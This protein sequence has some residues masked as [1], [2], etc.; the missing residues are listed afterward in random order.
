MPPLPPRGYGYGSGAPTTF[1]SAPVGYNVQP[2]S[3]PGYGAYQD[4]ASSAQAFGATQYGGFGSRAVYRRRL[5][6]VPEPDGPMDSGI[7][8]PEH[9][10]QAPGMH[11]H[12]VGFPHSHGAGSP[13]PPVNDI[14]VGPPLGSEHFAQHG[15]PFGD[16][17]TMR[18]FEQSSPFGM[19]GTPEHP[20]QMLPPQPFD[21]HL[22]LPP[23]DAAAVPPAPAR[24]Y[25]E[26]PPMSDRAMPP[27][28]AGAELPS[29]FQEAPGPLGQEPSGA[30]PAVELTRN[31][32]E[33]GGQAAP[34]LGQAPL[35]HMQ[36]SL[37]PGQGLP[38]PLAAQDVANPFEFGTPGSPPTDPQ[39]PNEHAAM[40]TGSGMSHE[41]PG[42]L[43]PQD[44]GMGPLGTATSPG[45][46]SFGN[47][48]M[49]SPGST[50][51]PYPPS[52]HLP[53]GAERDLSSQPGQTAPEQPIPV[54]AIPEMQPSS[55]QHAPEQPMPAQT[56]PEMQPPSSQPAPEQPMLAQTDLEQQPS[57]G[58]PTVDSQ[59]SAPAN[60]E[61]PLAGSQPL[62]IPAPP[63][64]GQEMSVVPGSGVPQEAQPGQEA[65]NQAHQAVPDS[66]SQPLRAALDS[67]MNQSPQLGRDLT[68][69]VPRAAPEGM[70]Q[71]QQAASEL[72][73]NPPQAASEA[74]SQS[75][76]ATPESMSLSLQA[77]P[78]AMQQQP[79]APGSMT[80]QRLDANGSPSTI[81]GFQANA[82]GPA[83]GPS[84]PS[85]QQPL[86]GA[87]AHRE[88]QA[89]S[90]S[91]QQL[92]EASV[93]SRT[94]S[95]TQ[96]PSSAAESAQA[97]IPNSARMGGV[98]EATQPPNNESSTSS[99]GDAGMAHTTQVQKSVQSQVPPSQL[100]L[101]MADSNVESNA[102]EN[103]RV[104]SSVNS[105][106]A[107]SL[108]VS[109]QPTN[110]EQSQGFGSAGMRQAA[111]TPP[112]SGD[113]MDQ[114]LA[115]NAAHASTTPQGVSQGSFGMSVRPPQG[116]SQESS[117]G[118]QQG[119]PW[120]PQG[121][122]STAS[123]LST[124]TDSPAQ[125]GQ[126]S[127][128]APPGVDKIVTRTVTRTLT[129][130]NDG[131]VGEMISQPM[132]SLKMPMPNT[133]AQMASGTMISEGPSSAMS[134]GLVSRQFAQTGRGLNGGAKFSGQQMKPPL[135]T[136][137]GTLRAPLEVRGVQTEVGLSTDTDSK[138]TEKSTDISVQHGSGGS[139]SNLDVGI[140]SGSDTNVSTSG[141]Q[142]PPPGIHG[143]G[144]LDGLCLHNSTH[145]SCGMVEA[146]TPEE[147][148]FVVNENSNPMICVRRPCSGKMVCACA[149]GANMLCKHTTV[150]TILVATVKHGDMGGDD[151]ILCKRDTLE[152]GVHVL[153]PMM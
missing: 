137:D 59:L 50:A 80:A 67:P 143:N 26:F 18:S 19:G 56:A 141:E 150:K 92:G 49:A 107:S 37:S 126:A 35:P 112:S 38:D 60:P 93:L 74:M 76:N 68:S 131:V 15:P 147:C 36:G 24:P 113:T 123:V 81:S 2:P 89:Q 133:G 31:G 42:S 61:L 43:P 45:Y 105:M 142:M 139:G 116:N 90:E 79:E 153:M 27:P 65:L 47:I 14:S 23:N 44:M 25:Q 1:P 152:D 39:L 3:Y 77:A 106:T 146:T 46:T 55:G 122:R 53:P 10:A 97:F 69:G 130:P 40:T 73:A 88:Y 84:A 32:N 22:G 57:S 86:S 104:P 98:S 63:A 111:V 134:N 85:A 78:E 82:P 66:I 7:A 12:P 16:A 13:Y 119:M 96:H 99:G 20:G 28:P 72:M 11:G 109:E 121:A 138:I 83:N 102:P 101:S 145:C 30:L 125:G 5:N 110:R 132:G 135:R 129:G 95:A 120:T 17:S 70:A 144:S 128:Q 75:S 4:P 114:G 71:S 117:T 62:Q 34:G 87:P 6:S 149:P 115:V 103:A 21:D 48:G 140:G 33:A 29:S 148:L 151:V 91:L 118:M 127:A 9:Y 54:H 94:D 8:G 124:S 58:Q 64:V 41:Q 52:P 136:H 108:R 51:G 100:A